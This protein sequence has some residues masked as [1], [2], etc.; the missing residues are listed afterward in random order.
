MLGGYTWT[1]DVRDSTI[2][3]DVY[4]FLS[5]TRSV[6]LPDGQSASVKMT[7]GMPWSGET[8]WELSGPEGVSWNVRVPTPGYARDIKVG[9]Y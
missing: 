8:K 9:A 3:L 7:S 2:S 6:T 1:A 5:A 4:L